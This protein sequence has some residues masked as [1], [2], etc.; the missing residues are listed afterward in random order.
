MDY[1]FTFLWSMTPIGELRVAIPLGMGRYDLPWY[2]VLPVSVIGNLIPG[3]FWLLV[4]P[5]LGNLVMGFRNPLGRLISWRSEALRRGNARRFEKYGAFGLTLLV[6]IP[7]P[8][9]GVWTAS[10]AAWVFE[11]PF[12]RALPAIA[13]GAVIA[14]GIVT[15]LTSVGILA[16]D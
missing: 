4:L 5:R 8:V 2:G 7:L 12:W 9:T 16:A 11:I 13:L 14:G 10:L 1:I 15:G 6:A 3:L